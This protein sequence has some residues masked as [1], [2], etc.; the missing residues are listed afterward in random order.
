[1]KW[2]DKYFY[3]AIG[4]VFTWTSRGLFLIVLMLFVWGMPI[5]AMEKD[6]QVDF[7]TGVLAKAHI[8]QPNT[9]AHE[10]K[11][12]S[13]NMD[14]AS[15]AGDAPKEGEL[16]AN[17]VHLFLHSYEEYKRLVAILGP[18]IS[19][20]LAHYILEN[21]P[22]E[23]KL[24][25]VMGPEMCF[26]TLSSYGQSSIG[27][28]QFSDSEDKVMTTDGSIAKIWDA[29]TG[30]CI[31]TLE[32]FMYSIESA[33]LNRAADKVITIHG[34]G[35]EVVAKVWD[36]PS[37]KCLHTLSGHTE[38]IYF[39]TFNKE[40]D[41]ILTI[42][43]DGTM[44][45]WD[46]ITGGCVKTLQEVGFNWLQKPLLNEARDR[47]AVICGY[48]T[49]KILDANT[50]ECIHSITLG[51]GRLWY[52]DF[53]ELGD[54]I[55]TGSCS[56]D[57]KTGATSFKTQIWDLVS[58][59]CAY[60]TTA[61]FPFQFIGNKI[62][63]RAGFVGP[64]EICD[65]VSDSF[66][67]RLEGDI[68]PGGRFHGLRA[69]VAT[70]C[71]PEK[72]VVKIWD[73]ET[74]ECIHTLSGHSEEVSSVTFS[75]T[76][77]IIATCSG[78][79]AKLWTIGRHTA[80]LN[81]KCTLEQAML[82]DCIYH[83]R[84]IGSYL[85]KNRKAKISTRFDFREHP[86]LQMHFETMPAEIR[87]I[88]ESCVIDK[89]L[90]APILK[91][92]RQNREYNAAFALVALIPLCSI[93]PSY[94]ISLGGALGLAV[95]NSKSERYFKVSGDR[96]SAS[97]SFAFLLPFMLSFFYEM[98]GSFINVPMAMSIL[99]PIL[100]SLI[101]LPDHAERRRIAERK[102]ILEKKKKERKKYF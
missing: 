47:L 96:A 2:L 25:N 45:I 90:L 34:N 18:D 26:H 32:G 79:T 41:K 76:G 9:L 44:K 89:S 53:N 15:L 57:A 5:S 39:A 7:C 51:H 23:K 86:H 31:T 70:V 69:K 58:G 64:T 8:E 97:F 82:L 59:E 28:V 75:R 30:Q 22:I 20:L 98:N 93:Y 73:V 52:L 100:F 92:L 19:R 77:D 87:S 71:N 55:M 99:W 12:I 21:H 6:S 81:K 85:K 60:T 38:R 35:N 33:V 66:V 43:Q 17:L 95:L 14:Q 80:W 102:R 24:R 11:V 91:W 88:L 62:V 63:K 36:L 84:N 83:T 49:V 16:E 54:R 27:S 10:D 74:G 72:N 65:I 3:K 13:R 37:G 1:M 50:G 4:L 94:K 40:G 101:D 46:V 42:S 56:E 48:E 68:L 29:D 61:E 67:H 78:K